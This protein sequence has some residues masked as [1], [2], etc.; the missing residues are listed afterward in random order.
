[1]RDAGFR[2]VARPHG[3]GEHGTAGGD[4]AHSETARDDVADGARTF[5]R[6]SPIW[7]CSSISARSIC[8]WRDAAARLKYA[9]PDPGPLSARDVAGRREKARARQRGGGA[10]DGVRA[11]VRLLQVASAADRCTSGIRS[12]RYALRPPARRRPPTA[13]RIAMLPGQPQR[14]IALSCAGALC[15]VSRSCA[16]ASE[17]ARRIWRGRRA[18]A[19]AGSN[20]RS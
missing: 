15:R 2:A 20:V 13:A 1:M 8:A 12:S 17:A 10:G 9:G 19:S 11:S 7:S 5:A 4:S 14:R 3:L 6:Q 16:H 18:R